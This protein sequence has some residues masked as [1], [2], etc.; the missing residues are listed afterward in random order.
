MCVTAGRFSGGRNRLGIRQHCPPI[1]ILWPTHR[2][3][4]WISS[5]RQNGTTSRVDPTSAARNAPGSA[6]T[7]SVVRC[8]HGFIATCR[9]PAMMDVVR[10]AGGASPSAS[11]QAVPM[12][13]F[14][15]L[16]RHRTGRIVP[17]PRA[18]ARMAGRWSLQRFARSCSGRPPCRPSETVGVLRPTRG[19][20][21]TS[22]IL[23]IALS[24]DHARPTG[25][26][27][28]REHSSAKSF[29]RPHWGLWNP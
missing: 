14:S 5:R 7:S 25:A 9:R 2:G 10:G 17:G 24:R 12:R 8:T 4:N 11:A 16:R 28:D 3:T 20:D 19:S 27:V 13:G 26:I 18:I 6:F 1:L 21:A 23:A 22:A 15:A 29:R